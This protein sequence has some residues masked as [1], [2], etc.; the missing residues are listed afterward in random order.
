MYTPEYIIVYVGFV[1]VFPPYCFTFLL[2]CVC[3]LRVADLDHTADVQLHSCE[4]PREGGREVCRCKLFDNILYTRALLM[5][6]WYY[7]L[8]Y[9]I[10]VVFYCYFSILYYSSINN[11]EA[12]FCTLLFFCILPQVSSF[13]HYYCLWIYA[14]IMRKV[15][16]VW[17]ACS[18]KLH[19]WQWGSLSWAKKD[20]EQKLLVSPNCGS[21]E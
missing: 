11:Y 3:L 20:D 4:C 13:S 9:I 6:I 19:K 10:I 12:F 17:R 5:V 21:E 2:F 8:L 7:S 14:I 1:I 16:R 18:R 15:A